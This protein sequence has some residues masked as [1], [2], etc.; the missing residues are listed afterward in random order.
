LKIK[1]VMLYDRPGSDNANGGTLT[2]SDGPSVSVTGI[3]TTGTAKVVTFSSR[4]ITWSNFQVSGGSGPNVGLSEFLIPYWGSDTNKIISRDTRPQ[5]GIPQHFY[6]G[7][8]GS[9]DGTVH[10]GTYDPLFEVDAANA[11]GKSSTYAYWTLI[12]PGYSGSGCLPNPDPYGWGT[13]QAQLLLQY[14]TQGKYASYVG[15]RVLFADIEEDICGWGQIVTNTSGIPIAFTGDYNR[16]RQVLRGFLDT[17]SNAF[18]PNTNQHFTP[19][20]YIR[21]EIWKRFFEEWPTGQPYNSPL[22]VV[23]YVAGNIGGVVCLPESKCQP[24]QDTFDDAFVL[25]TLALVT[26]KSIGGYK[27]V[28]WQYD[29]YDMDLAVQDPVKGFTPRR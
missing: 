26:D 28:I 17:I 14:A 23:L 19:G 20:I 7:Q 18:I 22:P 3:P 10:P 6:I 9:G 27:P 13:H 12:G 4:T 15:G 21:E 25:S 5:H 2:F 24:S 16:N 1:D 8:L 29:G 11:A